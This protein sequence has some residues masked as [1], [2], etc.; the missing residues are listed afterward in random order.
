MKPLKIHGK[1][2]QVYVRDDR[3]MVRGANILLESGDEQRT[4]SAIPPEGPDLG[5][6][7]GPNGEKALRE[8]NVWNDRVIGALKDAAEAGA[9]NKPF[10]IE[11][12]EL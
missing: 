4:F 9:A 5:A 10:T 3:K 8:L 6:W 1:P 12:I 2:T 7:I 11:L